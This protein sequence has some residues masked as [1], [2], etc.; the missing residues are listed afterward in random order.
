MVFPFF[1]ASFNLDGADSPPFRII[2][3][4]DFVNIKALDTL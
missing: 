1:V 3:F 2:L 4:W